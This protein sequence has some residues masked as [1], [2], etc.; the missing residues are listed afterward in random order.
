MSFLDIIKTLFPLVAIILLLFGVLLLVK[1]YT[2]SL[3]GKRIQNLHVDII[4]NQMIAPKKYLSLVR[5]KDKIFVLGISDNN[6]T[7]IKEFDYDES[8]ENEIHGSGVKQ[9]FVDV[10]KQNLGIK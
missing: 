5:I 8:F 7:L 6:I 10:L 2:F 3:T 9:N 1:K 4:H